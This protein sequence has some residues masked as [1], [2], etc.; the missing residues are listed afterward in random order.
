MPHAPGRVHC[1][2]DQRIGVALQQGESVAGLHLAR[3]QHA[4][5][6]AGHALLGD[7]AGD[8]LAAE[9]G[10]DLPAGRARLAELHARA[11]QGVDVADAG[12]GLV[13][14]LGG[15]IFA[16]GAADELL[17]QLGKLLRQPAMILQR[18]MMQRLF[19]PAVEAAIGLHVDFQ[20]LPADTDA[21]DHRLL[22][23]GGG[24]SVAR[25][26]TNLPGKQAE[27]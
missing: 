5:I 13:Q 15:N 10:V 8:A 6:P 11:A 18:K 12:A 1:A 4:V 20:A 19:H 27:Y 22:E 17:R 2:R 25:H 24:A 14:A 26:R 3:R 21:P 16:D 9:L 7:V 23:D